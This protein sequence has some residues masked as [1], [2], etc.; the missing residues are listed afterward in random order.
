MELIGLKEQLKNP[1]NLIFLEWPE[2]L[3]K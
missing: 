1:E 2:M 3:V